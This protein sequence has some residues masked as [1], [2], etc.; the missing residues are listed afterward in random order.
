MHNPLYH[1]VVIDTDHISMLPEYE[2]NGL[3]RLRLLV[4]WFRAT[5]TQVVP[6][7][8]RSLHDTVHLVCPGLCRL[9]ALC[10]IIIVDSVSLT[11]SLVSIHADRSLLR[12]TLIYPPPKI[13]ASRVWPDVWNTVKM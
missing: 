13:G 3:K 2:S 8:N 1:G 4:R 10:L 11:I 6:N 7:V 12:N 5:I 9:P